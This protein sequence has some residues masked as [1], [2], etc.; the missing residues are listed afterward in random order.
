[1]ESLEPENVQFRQGNDAEV[2]R[3][4]KRVVD[5]DA[6]RALAPP[7]LPPVPRPSGPQAG[8]PQPRRSRR[9]SCG[10]YGYDIY[11]S[12]RLRSAGTGSSPHR[13]VAPWPRSGPA[14][15]QMLF[16]LGISAGSRYGYWR[17]GG[18]ELPLDDRRV[19]AGEGSPKRRYGI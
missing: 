3:S 6:L 16:E 2:R 19:D 4:I 11:L 8:T 15:A 10:S 5:I 9:H 7:S 13:L 17:S 14:A 1:L 18:S 12:R